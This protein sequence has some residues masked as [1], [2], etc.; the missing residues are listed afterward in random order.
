[1]YEIPGKKEEETIHEFIANQTTSEL[2][3]ALSQ[4]STTYSTKKQVYEK[5]LT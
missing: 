1:L 3:N 5:L 4:L 2:K